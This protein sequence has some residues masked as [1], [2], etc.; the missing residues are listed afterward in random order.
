MQAGA[1]GSGRVKWLCCLCTLTTLIR[2]VILAGYYQT[3]S[4]GPGI[5]CPLNSYCP[6]AVAN[7]VSCYAPVYLLR[8]LFLAS[9]LISGLSPGLSLRSTIAPQGTRIAPLEGF[10]YASL[11]GLV[12]WH[13]VARM[14]LTLRASH[15]SQPCQLLYRAR[16]SHCLLSLVPQIACPESTV[17]PAGSS[18]AGN[19]T[20]LP[21]FFAAPGNAAAACTAGS[22]CPGGGNIFKCPAG[23]TSPP[24]T[25]SLAACTIMPGFYGRHESPIPLLS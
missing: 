14:C 7:A 23:S 18:I 12:W 13:T 22:Y 16:E 11:E 15:A 5:V 6:A 17:S 3:T 9:L 25:S 20:S 10:V 24:S 4:G 8:Y 19:C 21:G 2:N 1:G